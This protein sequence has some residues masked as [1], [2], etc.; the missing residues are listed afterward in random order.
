[1]D[2]KSHLLPV[3]HL[4][5]TRDHCSLVILRTLQA[6][7]SQVRF[8]LGELINT[9]NNNQPPNGFYIG[10]R[11]DISTLTDAII[12]HLPLAPVN[13]IPV[14]TQFLCSYRCVFCQNVEP[15]TMRYQRPFDKIPILTVAQANANAPVSMGA[16]LTN[17]IQTPLTVNCRVCGVVNQGNMR[18][19]RG[20]YTM[21]RMRQY[22]SLE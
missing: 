21:L 18:V 4:R 5:Q 22:A 11:E 13:G 9:W 1:M 8:D 3:A 17:L 20:K 14:L 19:I 16:L 7:P 2:L 15:G 10:Q 6:L 12:G